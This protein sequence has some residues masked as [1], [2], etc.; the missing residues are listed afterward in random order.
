MMYLAIVSALFLLVMVCALVWVI[1]GERIREKRYLARLAQVNAEYWAEVE[2]WSYDDMEE[3][4]NNVDPAVL[5]WT[6]D[7]G[8]K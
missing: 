6:S 3:V 7:R 5:T 1:V 4:P 2:R 8:S